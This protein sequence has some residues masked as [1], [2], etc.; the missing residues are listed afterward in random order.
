MIQH[1]SRGGRGVLYLLIGLAFCVVGCTFLFAESPVPSSP[2]DAMRTLAS[3]ISD[4]AKGQA[5][6]FLV[7]AQNGDELLTMGS[8]GR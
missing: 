7:I 3:D 6:A 2:R 5:P 1:S 4:Y 8:A